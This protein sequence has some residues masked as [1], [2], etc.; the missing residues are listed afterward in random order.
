MASDT[1]L[2]SSGL[3][4]DDCAGFAEPADILSRLTPDDLHP[5]RLAGP[6]AWHP[7]GLTVSPPTDRRVRL[8]L[9][10]GTRPHAGDQLLERLEAQLGRTPWP[11]TGRLDVRRRDGQ[12]HCSNAN[13]QRS[14]IEIET[15]S[16]VSSRQH[17]EVVTRDGWPILDEIAALSDRTR[18]INVEEPRRTDL[19]DLASW[20]EHKMAEPPAGQRLLTSLP[21]L[22]ANQERE[23][24]ASADRLRTI[25]AHRGGATVHQRQALD[26]L[27]EQLDHCWSRGHG[28]RR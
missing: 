1:T 21:Q 16:E 19:A 7:W 28:E 2:A 10:A 3:A 18:C 22:L 9:P 4:V 11:P 5:A 27:A 15:A 13:A 23:H 25:L 20:V 24:P 26:Y 17:A 12:L 8:I 14:L 6:H